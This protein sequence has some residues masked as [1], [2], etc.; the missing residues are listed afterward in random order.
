MQDDIYQCLIEFEVFRKPKKQTIE[1]L[2]QS[3]QI[4]CFK[5]KTIL[6]EERKFHDTVYFILKGMVAISKL[7]ANGQKKV[8]FLLCKGNFFNDDMIEGLPSAVS[9]E[10][11][12]NCELLMVSR[13]N[14]YELMKQ[15]FEF[16]KVLYESV[17]MKTRRLYR[18]LKNTPNA[19]KIEKRLAAKFFKLA[20][21]YGV[22][23]EDG[24][25]IKM[26]ISITYLADL[27]GSQR[28]TISRALK[29][30]QQEK[31]IRMEKRKF[32]IP[33]VMELSKYFKSS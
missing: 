19:I 31:L 33:D 4:S 25:L 18:Q 20:K 17:S 28:E 27:L 11:Y 26:D 8:M 2:I 5:E 21:D 7:N 23:Q 1:K 14:V 12:E 3:S 29:V 13:A 32:L 10:V 15:D 22:V 24:V 9:A 30:L 6:F 16:A